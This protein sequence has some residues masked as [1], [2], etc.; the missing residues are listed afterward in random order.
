MGIPIERHKRWQQG[1]VPAVIVAV[2]LVVGVLL[3]F[4]LRQQP[5][6]FEVAKHS[7][8]GASWLSAVRR[9]IEAEEYLPRKDGAARLASADEEGG[10]SF[11]NRAHRVRSFVSRDGWEVAPRSVDQGSPWRW[12]YRFASVRRGDARERV[13]APRVHEKGGAVY[14]SYTKEL[15]EWYR[16]SRSGI[17]QGFG[18]RERPYPGAGGELVLE[19]DVATDL[20]ATQRERGSITFSRGADEV[21]VYTGLK[22][23]DANGHEVPSWL[24]S[25]GSSSIRIHIDD[26]QARYPVMVDP[27]LVDAS[28]SGESNQSNA[29]FGAAVANAGDVNGDGYGD[30]IVGAPKYDNGDFNEGRAYLYLGSA[31]GLSASPSWIGE[32]NQAGTFYGQGV[33]A[34]GDVNNDGYSDVIVGAYQYSNGEASEG[35][36]FL[37]MGSQ[38]GLSTSAAWVGEPNQAG[39]LYG[40]RVSTAG[41]VNGDGFGD[42]LVGACSFANGESGEGAAFLYLG[43]A[44]GLSSTASWRGESNQ[45]DANYGCRVASAG[46]VNADGYSDILVGAISYDNVEEDE[47]RAFL[48]LGSSSGVSATASW[49]GEPDQ[50][51]VSYSWSISSAGDVNGDGYGDV[52]VGAPFFSNNE[53]SEGRVYLYLGSSSG[54]SIS[55]SWTNESNRTNNWYGAGAAGA[56]DVNRDGYSDVVVGAPFLSNSESDEGAIYLYLGAGSGL[57]PAPD[58]VVES[59]VPGARFGWAVSGAGDTNRDN[60]SDM[61]IGSIGLSNP[62]S[63]EGGAFLFSNFS[64]FVTPSPTPSVTPTRTPTATVTPTRTATPTPTGTPT[65]TVTPTRTPAATPTARPISVSPGDGDLPPAQFE[66]S[67]RN[68]LAIL[69]EAVPELSSK[70]RARAIEK[71]VGRGISRQ[72]ATQAVKSLEVEYVLTVE[73]VAVS[74]VRDHRSQVLPAGSRGGTYRSRN[75]RI[76][77]RNLN[78]GNYSGSYSV[79][80]YTRSPSVLI[81]STR[82]SRNSTFRIGG[83]LRK[84]ETRVSHD[85]PTFGKLVSETRVSHDFPTFS[86]FSRTPIRDSGPTSEGGRPKKAESHD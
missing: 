69:P 35:R 68:P 2:C 20:K 1:L 83:G 55:A 30:V 56:G 19:G 18:I 70:Q 43:S 54:L 42:V 4:L 29:D 16:N 86:G 10:F 13:G 64:Q 62:E 45:A 32:S 12:R 46:D 71:L 48:Y 44:S 61:L 73:R 39:A 8:P 57:R 72:R 23:I 3:G 78:P 59:D 50:A 65:P 53:G 81:G 51:Y 80:I 66:V 14:L 28:W 36:A 25:E 38:S 7:A 9:S 76:S 52:I 21:F 11:S 84:G 24:S 6:R 31:S 22:V 77:L 63:Q 47:G 74:E 82:N 67:G 49:T 26:S 75:N 60:F 34:A 85:F 17:E 15:T 58:W 40:A 41:D 37:Y 27:T 33:S 79:N 5:A